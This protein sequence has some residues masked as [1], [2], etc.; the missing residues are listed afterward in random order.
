MKLLLRPDVRVQNMESKTDNLAD[1]LSNLALIVKK[2]QEGSSTEQ[3]NDCQF[4]RMK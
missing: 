3:A 4:E 2:G 1:R